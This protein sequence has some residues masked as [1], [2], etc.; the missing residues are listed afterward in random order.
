MGEGLLR[1]LLLGQKVAEHFGGTKKIGNNVDTFGRCAQ[2]PQILRG[3]GIERAVHGRGVGADVP[4]MGVPYRW[5]APDGSEVLAVLHYL[6]NTGALAEP[7]DDAVATLRAAVASSNP[8]NLPVVL[9]GNGG[10]SDGAPPQA[11]LPELVAAFNAA[12]DDAEMTIGTLED[13]FDAIEALDPAQWAVSEGEQRSG[14]YNVM[15]WGVPSARTYL[16]VA[17]FEAERELFRYAEPMAAMAWILSGDDY[18]A[19]FTEHALRPIMENH[20]HDTICGCSGDLVYHDAMH[21]F[22]VSRQ[23][24]QMLL[25]RAAKRMAGV[26]KTQPPT[27]DAMP[28]V[29]FNPLPYA[30]TRRVRA[31]VY[32]PAQDQEAQPFHVTGP[33]G[34]PVRAQILAQRVRPFFQPYFWRRNMLS[35]TPVR[36]LDVV[37]EA[38]APPVG[39]AGYF[40]TPG[41]GPKLGTTLKVD[42]SGLENEFLRVDLGADGLIALT[43]KRTAQ[44]YEGLNRFE[45]EESL[46][47]EYYHVTGETPDVRVAP[48]PKRVTVTQRGPIKATVAMEYDWALPA[49][50]N[51]DLK[52]RSEE[53]VVCPMRVEVSLWAD[54]PRVEF[55]V[56]FDN[57]AHDHRL[58]A[59]FPTGLETDGIDIESPFA[60]VRRSVDL[61][62]DEGWLDPPCQESP[63]QTFTD[64]SDGNVGLAVLNLGLPEIGA[65]R[66]EG[67]VELGLTLLRAVGWIARLHWA[68]AGYRVPAPEAQCLGKQTFRYALYPH[69]RDWKLGGVLSHA[70]DYVFPAMAYDPVAGTGTQ[71]GASLLTVAPTSMVLSACKRAEKGDDL[72]V[73]LWNAEDK[74]VEAK[75]AF[76]FPVEAAWIADMNEEP[77]EVLQVADGQISFAAGPCKIMTLRVTPGK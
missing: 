75:V 64:A 70:Q 29:V 69:G 55:E 76:G 35:E 21:R 58:R 12:S 3:F 31:K 8:M 65:R 33:E 43:D 63:Q 62:V 15:L 4:G 36:E 53:T 42:E 25:E 9:I 34:N 45:D 44:R 24:S 1:N 57:L 16:K 13:Y 38:K 72:I 66:V 17:N 5:V 61:P 59:V 20:F 51:D 6:Q 40:V 48:A 14:K 67:G 52:T 46:C 10:G 54:V 37:F 73:R 56:E 41:E 39:C 47:G 7:V 23:V 26:V 74:A 18:P 32:L 30:G 71:A 22:E 2:M 28:L 77:L 11:R 49:C 68:V 19:P 60:V 50:A 27:P